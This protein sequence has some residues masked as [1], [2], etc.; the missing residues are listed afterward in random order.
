[1]AKKKPI[2]ASKFLIGSAV[3]LYGKR[4][5]KKKA[6]LVTDGSLKSIKPPYIVVANHS[7]FADVGGLVVAA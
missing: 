4:Y 5:F 3:N 7:G 2:L 1:M 6:R